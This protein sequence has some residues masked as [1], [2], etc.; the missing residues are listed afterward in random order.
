MI[1]RS[2]PTMPALREPVNRAVVRVPRSRVIDMS[3]M[4]TTIAGIRIPNSTIAR[5]T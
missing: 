3:A 1:R 2:E 5:A 4:H